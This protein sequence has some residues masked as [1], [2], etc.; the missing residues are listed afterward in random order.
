MFPIKFLPNPNQKELN[1]D[2]VRVTKICDG[3]SCGTKYASKGGK[4]I[5][6]HNNLQA[7]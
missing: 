5:C 3:K 2:I 1:F 7:L 6:I 4:F